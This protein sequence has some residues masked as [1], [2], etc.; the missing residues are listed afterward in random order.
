M[1]D[2]GIMKILKRVFLI[3]IGF[4]LFVIILNSYGVFDNL[5]D[6]KNL[7]KKADKAL[8][9]GLRQADEG[10][11]RKTDE[12]IMNTMLNRMDKK[13]DQS[14]KDPVARAVLKRHIRESE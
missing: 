14:T 8:A 1:I 12:I 3:L 2:G 9:S 7:S 10:I 4:T 6:V 13:I 5:I 11:E